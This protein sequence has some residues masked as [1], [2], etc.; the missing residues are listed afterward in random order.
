[1]QRTESVKKALINKG[2]HP[3]R[4]LTQYHGIDYL[5]TS[6][7]LARRVDIELLIRN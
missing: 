3:T 7:S 1:M 4:I 2:V 5:S 6:E